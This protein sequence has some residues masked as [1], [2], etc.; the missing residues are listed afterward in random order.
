MATFDITDEQIVLMIDRTIAVAHKI[1]IYDRETRRNKTLDTTIL[2]GI[3]EW[4]DHR[5][6]TDK[7]RDA[8]YNIYTKFKIKKFY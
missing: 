5:D 6:L 3:K 1:K 4:K 2:E 8:V 7:Q